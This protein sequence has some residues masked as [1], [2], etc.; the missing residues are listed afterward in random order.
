MVPGDGAQGV[1]CTGDFEGSF[2]VVVP[3]LAANTRAGGGSSGSSKDVFAHISSH[4][5]G[6][7]HQEQH[8]EV[9]MPEMGLGGQGAIRNNCIVPSE[10]CFCHQLAW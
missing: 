1:S 10:D 6:Q 9:C 8:V 4:L 7:D 3:C 5:G 2:G